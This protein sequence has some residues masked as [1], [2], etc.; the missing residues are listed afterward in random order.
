MPIADP[1]SGY[2]ITMAPL[3]VEGLVVVGVSGSEFGI[4][5]FL[6]AY[7]TRTGERRWRFW[8]IPSP[9]EGGWWGSWVTTTPDGDPL[10]R[11]IAREKRDSARY[12]ESWRHGGG[13]LWVTPSYDPALRTLYIG[14]GNPAPMYNG[15]TRP[16]D[17]L[18]TGAIVALDVDRGTR[19]WHYQIAPHDEADR[20]MA[21]PIVLFDRVD[22]DSVVPAL[23][24]ANKTGWVYV[25]HRRTGR[26]LLR[27][28]ALVPQ[29]N[30][31]TPGSPTEN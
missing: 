16:G 1:D 10:D 30:L 3:A 13:G 25:L 12:A 11:D 24:Q 27:S 15:R 29:H 5:G 17:N 20:D 18:Y 2:S 22:G 31:F 6:D 14:T 4:R 23:A 19:K 9:A 21:A 7:D 26:Q 8:T 28:E